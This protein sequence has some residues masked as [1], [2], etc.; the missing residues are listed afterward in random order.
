MMKIRPRT[1]PRLRR[2]WRGMWQVGVVLVC[3]ISYIGLALLLQPTRQDH[4]QQTSQ[5]PLSAKKPL[6]DSFPLSE[7]EEQ[8]M[9]MFAAL[10]GR[11]WSHRELLQEEGEGEG[12]EEEVEGITE[13]A[14]PLDEIFNETMA[15]ETQVEAKPLF[16]ED[17]FT[18]DQRRKGA[19][20]LHVLGM[21]YMFVALALVCDEFFV[22]ALDVIIEKAG[23]SEDVAGATFMA[24]GGSAPELFTSIIGVFISFDDVGI[25]TIVGSAVF[26]ILFV[27]AM[28]VI[29]SKTVLDLTW[30][31][32][33]RDVT[34]YSVALLMLVMFFR[35][36]AVYW[37][38]A[39]FMFSI[40]ITYCA[41]MK[42]NSA[43][44]KFVKKQLN[45]NKVT[46]VC[47]TDQLVPN[48]CGC[49]SLLGND[50]TKGQQQHAGSSTPQPQQEGPTRR[51]SAPVLHSG[52]KFRHGLLQLMIHTIDPLHDGKV[53]E[54][55]TQLHAIASLKVLLD[56]T[57]PQNG[58]VE[59]Y[60]SGGLTPDTRPDTQSHV[61]GRSS[62]G[63]EVTHIDSLASSDVNSQGG[64]AGGG[65]SCS[66]PSQQY[67]PSTNGDLHADS[68]ANNVSYG[69]ASS[70]RTLPTTNKAPL[71]NTTN[72]TGGSAPPLTAIP[73]S[74]HATAPEQNSHVPDAA[75]E[76]PGAA[77]S[78]DEE[79][80]KPLDLSWPDT[81][82]KRLTYVFV[83]PLIIPLWLTLPDTRTPRGKQ[84][85]FI[86]FIGSI[87]WIAAF[88]YLMV[89]WATIVGQTIYITPEVMGLTILAA[90]TS[91]PDLIT[92]VIVA[93]KG[94]GDMAVSSSV[95]SNIFDVCVGLPVPW[96]LF[97]L[98]ELIK[99][100]LHDRP[101][102]WHVE[103]IL[104][105]SEGMACSIMM[106]FSMLMFVIISIACSRW[107][108]KKGLG[109]TMFILYFIFVA[110]SLC[111]EY[112]FLTC[113][114]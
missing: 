42:C 80:S 97:A 48:A 15:N 47:S 14:I 91:V 23:I 96:M 57:K 110:L 19:I 2:R 72:G 71:S 55:A 106:L 62:Q 1:R 56:A 59:T 89:W 36:N 4:Q 49:C 100:F 52:T 54:K 46:R 45:R 26:N 25:G 85:F 10:P 29:F 69:T 94:F 68:V 105:N 16:P 88:S 12:A 51:P 109:L 77:D 33:F 67:Q 107:K 13:E 78:D 81:C 28:C 44:E 84:F 102:P 95:G 27:I 103:P 92:S 24:A 101:N 82:R 90:G 83:A 112:N 53:D 41:F 39:L 20:I 93:R 64:G 98:K 79:E 75:S 30:W 34:F 61:S 66:G 35:D 86:T 87:L 70:L 9:A 99:N 60:R 37:Y 111:F 63:T 11:G 113:S 58:R 38:E 32:L 6:G 3:S 31:P 22:P 76:P 43:I 108:M 65:S 8:L 114:I 18:P 17:L 40:Y 104:V 73:P 74:L 50:A 21:I 7:Q 5:L